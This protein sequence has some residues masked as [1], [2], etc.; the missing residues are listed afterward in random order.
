MGTMEQLIRRILSQ[1]LCCVCNGP[2]G[3]LAERYR[4]RLYRLHQR[5]HREGPFMTRGY[6]YLIEAHKP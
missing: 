3:S 2:L 5:L 6:T 1:M 4:E